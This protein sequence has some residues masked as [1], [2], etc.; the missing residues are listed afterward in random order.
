MYI[1]M[2]MC[3]CT[4]SVHSH[5]ISRGFGAATAA[6]RFTGEVGGP[7][8]QVV[9]GGVEQVRCPGKAGRKGAKVA[10]KCGFWWIFHGIL[11]IFNDLTL[12]KVDFPWDFQ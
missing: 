3:M 7:A 11:R 1:Y 8:A 4:Q 12:E 6:L 10:G 2:N 5:A 9:T